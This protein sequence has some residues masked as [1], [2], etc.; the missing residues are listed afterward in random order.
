[1]QIK[2]LNV[3]EFDNFVLNH[4]LGSYYQTSNYALVMA[5][6]KFDY[7]LIGYVDNNNNIKAAALIL[8]KKIGLFN[9][10]GYSP[11]GFLIDYNNKSLVKKFTEDLV[12]YYSK[13]GLSFIKINPEIVIGE[14]INDLI[15]YNSNAKIKDYLE[16]LGYKSLKRTLNFETIVPRFNAILPLRDYNLFGINKQTRNKIKKSMRKGLEFEFGNRDSITKIFEFVGKKHNHDILYYKDFYNVFSKNDL[17]DVILV[18]INVDKFLIESKRLFESELEVNTRLSDQILIDNSDKNIKTKMQSDVKLWAYKEDMTTATK[19]AGKY[20]K[21]IYIAGAIIIKF[22]DRIHIIASGFDK[23]FDKFVPNYFLHH[24]IFEYYKG[25][26]NFVDLN[27]ITGD[28]SRENPYHGLN[29]FKE[30]FKPF[31]YEFIGEFDLVINQL[32]YSQLLNTGVLNKEF[33]KNKKIF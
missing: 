10:Y 14:V 29:R 3:M 20:D 17:I 27:G 26:Y 32:S 9:K 33:I 31:E 15:E 21:E 19:F 25:K 2:E 28:F 30:G 6:Y 18:K 16:T 4:P 8:H 1:M 7:D 23:E 5:E 24:N 12:K 22:K 11:K 13:K